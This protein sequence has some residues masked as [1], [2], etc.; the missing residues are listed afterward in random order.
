MQLDYPQLH[1]VSRHKTTLLT[2]PALADKG[3]VFAFSSRVGGCSQ[4]P[5]D[6]LNLAYPTQL[7]RH[8][9]PGDRQAYPQE[10]EAHTQANRAAILSALGAPRRLVYSRQVHGNQI[11]ELSATNRCSWTSCHP[12]GEQA[13]WESCVGEVDGLFTRD[14]GYTLMLL[15]ADCVP[16]VLAAPGAVCV[17]HSGWRG[18]FSHI[19]SEGIRRICECSSCHPSDLNLYLGPHIAAQ[20]YEVS[21]E[22]YLR[23]QGEFSHCEP[24]YQDERGAYHLDMSKLIVHD[25]C[26]A[27]MDRRRIALS[28]Y[29]TLQDPQRYFS[30]RLSKGICG[31]QGALAYLKAD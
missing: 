8:L 27:G 30:F 5:Y 19:V 1:L 14:T 29:S 6:T 13:F 25:A 10:L 3:V 26:E 4:E 22:L 23:F 9:A 31:R 20:D 21:Q 12:E 17:M 18:C 11:A 16:L 15:F 7:F 28:P 2:D 24:G